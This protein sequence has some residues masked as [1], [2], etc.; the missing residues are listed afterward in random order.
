[1]I[2]YYIS[3]INL[4]HDTWYTYTY[5]SRFQEAAIFRYNWPQLWRI[6]AFMRMRCQKQQDQKFLSWLMLGK[7]H[8]CPAE[9]SGSCNPV[10][11]S[12]KQLCRDAVKSTHINF[13][14][15]RAITAFSQDIMPER[16]PWDKQHSLLLSCT[17]LY[18]PF[19][20]V[21][22]IYCKAIG[23]L[24]PCCWQACCSPEL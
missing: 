23:L 5:L 14:E 7:Y 11:R 15:S 3:S 22:K 4:K 21:M 9:S 10:S 8:E 12:S 24:C 1:M 17:R 19:H 16:M 13:E 20:R 2:N 18:S 6:L